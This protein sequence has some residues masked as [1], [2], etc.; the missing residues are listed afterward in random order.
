M[1]ADCSKTREVVEKLAE[2]LN[3]E[4]VNVSAAALRWFTR[5]YLIAVKETAGLELA[6]EIAGDILEGITE[7]IPDDAD[8]DAAQARAEEEWKA[9]ET[10][11]QKMH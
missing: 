7:V 11:T 5:A 10:E 4:D 1:C 8:Y 6:S 2:I 9:I 3:P